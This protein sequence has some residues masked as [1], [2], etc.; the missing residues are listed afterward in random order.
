MLS[1]TARED[2]HKLFP[3]RSRSFQTDGFQDGVVV[4]FRTFYLKIYDDRYEYAYHVAG[5]RYNEINPVFEEC[6]PA[7]KFKKFASQ[8]T[9]EDHLMGFN[10]YHCRDCCSQ[11]RV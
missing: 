5:Y 2:L 7:S 8:F 9:H 4:R 3:L 10:K 1:C 11:H 6:V